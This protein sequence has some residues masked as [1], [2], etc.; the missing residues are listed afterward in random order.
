M[1]FG[2]AKRA[3]VARPDA[4]LQTCSTFIV[5]RVRHKLLDVVRSFFES[6]DLAF[7]VAGEAVEEER[8]AS[9]LDSASVIP[10]LPR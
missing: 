10:F 5:Q 3:A 2:G 7:V 9:L 1:S 8:M 6:D 4:T